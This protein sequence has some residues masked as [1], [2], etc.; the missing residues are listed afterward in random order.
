MAKQDYYEVL[1]VQKTAS[2]DEI[3]KAYR[4]LAIKYHPDKNPGDKEAEEK[5]KAV[6]EAYEVLSDPQKRQRYDQFGFDDPMGQGGFGGGAGFNPFDIFN[7]FFRGGS[8]GGGGFSFSFGDDDEAGAPRG[9]D[10]R[11]RVTVTLQDIVNG[12]EKQFKIKK[13]APCKDCNGTGAKNGTEMETC[14]KC[15]GRGR[16]VQVV[17]S[18]FGRMQT[19]APCPE[20][21]GTGKHIKTKCPKCNGEGVELREEIVKV[22]I[23]A[24][25]FEG[26]QLTMQGYG[27][28][29]R[30]GGPNGDLL[31][32]I[33]EE[34]QDNFV[35]SENNLYHNLI[36]DYPTAALGGEVEIPLVNGTKKIRIAPGTQPSTKIIQRGEGLPTYG[37]YGRGDL[38]VE[39]QVYVPE[40]VDDE[41]R[42]LLEEMRSRKHFS[43]TP[44]FIEKAKTKFRNLFR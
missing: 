19:E 25:V 6:A 21:H 27:H 30:Q 4:K 8:N 37:R 31:V 28:A 11:I 7:S 35:R 12:V 44:S 3:K 34:K 2:D 36:I 10:I 17:N 39:V 33:V 23:P 42:K 22:K 32:V 15:K 41:D 13:Y 5:F 16:V 14:P 43:M 20:C 40:L 18:L 24:G 29:G 1:G 26:M 38:I 9:G